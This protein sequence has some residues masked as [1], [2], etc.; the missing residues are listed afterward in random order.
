MT[1]VI[2]TNGDYK[3]QA[4]SNGA[5]ITL[6]TPTVVVTGN[7]TVEGTRTDVNVNN[8]YIEDNIINVNNGESPTH[9]GITLI[10]AGLEINRGSA[11]NVAVLYNETSSAW[12]FVE[13][14]QSGYTTTNSKIK[15]RSII[16]DVTNNGGNLELIGDHLG[17]ITVAALESPNNY[18]TQILNR[19]RDD[20]IPNKGYVDYAIAN[21]DPQPSLGSDDTTIVA[22]D[23]DV[24]NDGVSVSSIQLTVDGQDNVYL[25]A[26]KTLI[27]DLEFRS[28]IIENVNSL[29]NIRILTNGTGKLET[30]Y[31]IQLGQILTVSQPSPVA[32]T[33]VVYSKTPG[34]ADSGIYFVN[35]SKR[36]ELISKNK[37][38]VFSMIF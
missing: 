20:D 37:A 23:K 4:K 17:V 12:E 35:N 16:T 21:R 28:N 31:A 7:L 19:G 33:T 9:S 8:L 30:N 1:Q 10:Y 14:T 36:D 22:R 34:A 32:D 3:I 15:V 25:Y 26:D 29:G 6:D 27:H 11:N 24:L 38:L 2:R 18:T 13:N 5:V